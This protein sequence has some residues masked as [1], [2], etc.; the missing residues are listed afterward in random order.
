[1]PHASEIILGQKES[2]I[3]QG[4]VHLAC[5]MEIKVRSLQYSLRRVRRRRV[6]MWKIEGGVERRTVLNC[7]GGIVV[8]SF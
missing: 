6:M 7:L 3:R 5:S 8:L 2:A 4:S 1:V